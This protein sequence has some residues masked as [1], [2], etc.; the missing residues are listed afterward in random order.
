MRAA[1]FMRTIQKKPLESLFGIGKR[2]VKCF[3]LYVLISLQIYIW[4]FMLL[5]HYLVQGSIVISGMR[6]LSKYESK[7]NLLVQLHRS[8]SHLLE[9]LLLVSILLQEGDML[10]VVYPFCTLANSRVD[11]HYHSSKGLPKGCPVHSYGLILA[12]KFH[13]HRMAPQTF[14]Q[15]MQD[16]KCHAC[17]EPPKSHL[18]QLLLHTISYQGLQMR[19]HNGLCLCL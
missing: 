9:T 16:C 2:R 7:I 18:H 19:T 13:L 3:G 12:N 11:P 8:I 1:H 6:N 4:Y 14:R 10:E 17:W 5:L 15:G